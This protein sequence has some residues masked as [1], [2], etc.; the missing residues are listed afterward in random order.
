LAAKKLADDTGDCAATK[1]SERM[2]AV[3]GDDHIVFGYRSLET[4]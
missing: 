4:D 2:A 3:G 1:D